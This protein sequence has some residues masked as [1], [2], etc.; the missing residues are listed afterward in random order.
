MPAELQSTGQIF[1]C[2]TSRLVPLKT[3]NRSLLL[4]FHPQG[5]IRERKRGTLTVISVSVIF[6]VCW[7]ADSIRYILAYYTSTPV[8]SDAITNTL[9][10]F[11]S[12]INPIVYAL[13][14]QRF[15]EKMK[16]MMSCCCRP[17]TNRIMVRPARGPQ[18]MQVVN[19]TTHPNLETGESSKE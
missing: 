4:C 14:N 11:N 3:D 2:E 19:S 1:T 12:A 10:I 13:V 7:L 15:R 5:V 17:A 6:G 8:Y 16:P 9:I 18:R